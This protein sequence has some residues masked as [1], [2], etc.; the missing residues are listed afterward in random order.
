M[1][2][3]LFQIIEIPHDQSPILRGIK[4]IRQNKTIK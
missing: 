2:R 1:E 3:Q 4:Y